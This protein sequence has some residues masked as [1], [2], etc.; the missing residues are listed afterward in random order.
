MN[1]RATIRGSAVGLGIAELYQH[2]NDRLATEGV[3]VAQIADQAHTSTSRV[4]AYQGA[5]AGTLLGVIAIIEAQATLG[6]PLVLQRIAERCGFLLVPAPATPDGVNDELAA[7]AIA[8][9]LKE[10]TEA[11]QVFAKVVGDGKVTPKELKEFRA[12]KREAE[13]ALEEL[14]CLASRRTQA[15]GEKSARVI[16][17]G[18]ATRA[19]GAGG[20]MGPPAPPSPEDEI[21]QRRRL[22]SS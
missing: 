1:R 10:F 7:A 21:E 6:Q 3:S 12:E 11:V 15:L 5:D 2:A 17:S 19:S 13:Q 20:V 4:Y 18:S 16:A 9:S 8:K 22:P 14:D